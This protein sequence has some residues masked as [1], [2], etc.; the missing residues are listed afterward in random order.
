MSLSSNWL[1][2]GFHYLIWGFLYI[3]NPSPLLGTWLANIFLWICSLC[4]HP[5]S[6]ILHGKRL[7]FIRPIYLFFSFKDCAFGV[8]P[9]NSSSSPR[10]WS[11]F[12][13]PRG[14]IDL[15]FT[16]KSVTHFE[17]YPIVPAWLVEKTILTPL[18]CFCISVKKMQKLGECLCGS[19]S[20]VPIQF[21]WSIYLSL[22]QNQLPWLYMSWSQVD[23][24]LLLHSYAIL[25]SYCC[26]FNSY[27]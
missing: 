11:S 2:V 17:L 12:F 8:K 23:W 26:C 13:P 10:S 18:N 6:S 5:V 20:G 22:H 16:F 15:H 19:V 7:I 9:K 4:F 14:F 21:H 27:S 1:V 24:F 25:F 3:L